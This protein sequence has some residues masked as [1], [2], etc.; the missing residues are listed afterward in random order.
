MIEVT[1]KEFDPS[2]LGSVKKGPI[3]P[4]K[5]RSINSNLNNTNDEFA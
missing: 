5:L 1:S 4:S 3:S 2:I